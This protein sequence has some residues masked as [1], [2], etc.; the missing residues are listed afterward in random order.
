VDNFRLGIRAPAGLNYIFAAAPLDIFLE[1]AP[2]LDVIN[3]TEFR[4]TGAIGARY[5]F[6]LYI[7]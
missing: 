2:V 7:K 4:L 6:F 5:F 1:I 3:K